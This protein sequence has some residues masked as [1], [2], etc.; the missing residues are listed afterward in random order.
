MAGVGAH[1][2]MENGGSRKSPP[3]ENKTCEEDP[4]V[5]MRTDARVGEGWMLVKNGC[6]VID[7]PDRGV[8]G[9]GKVPME[10][11]LWFWFWTRM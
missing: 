1:G 5:P 6:Q 3:S 11:L 10:S 2:T 7:G 8:I 9:K 4:R